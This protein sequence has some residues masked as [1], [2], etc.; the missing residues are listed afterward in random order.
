[1]HTYCRWFQSHVVYN[2][3]LRSIQYHEKFKVKI[4]LKYLSWVWKFDWWKKTGTDGPSGS[5]NGISFTV[6]QLTSN[7][8][9]LHASWT[10]SSKHFAMLWKSNHFMFLILSVTTKYCNVLLK[11]P[12]TAVQKKPGL[13]TMMSSSSNVCCMVKNCL[14]HWDWKVFCMV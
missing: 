12:V 6:V 10:V 3:I 11:Y 9:H 4:E 8:F 2:E 14:K 13:T 5:S 1:M 7:K